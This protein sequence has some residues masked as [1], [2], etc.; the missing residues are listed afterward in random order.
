M[1]GV[2]LHSFVILFTPGLLVLELSLLNDEVMKEHDQTV[3]RIDAVADAV[4]SLFNFH[5]QLMIKIRR[6]TLMYGPSNQ[7]RTI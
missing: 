6:V 3:G 4:Q 7:Q 2:S 5:G 1:Q